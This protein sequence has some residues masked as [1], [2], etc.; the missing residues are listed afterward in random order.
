MTFKRLVYSL[1]RF[2]AAT[3]SSRN[4]PW[5]LLLLFMMM[6][7][8]IINSYNVVS[9]HQ[10]SIK[11]V[12]IHRIS[13]YICFPRNISFILILFFLENSDLS[14]L[15]DLEKFQPWYLKSDLGSPKTSSIMHGLSW[16]SLETIKQRDFHDP[17]EIDSWIP[18]YF[19][20]TEIGSKCV[21]DIES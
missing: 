1:A 5:L 20:F 18:F 11:L 15:V 4:T 8:L 19:F 6:L 2:L 7:P 14:A 16:N 12:S 9:F 13:Q 3:S 10:N 21:C 17:H